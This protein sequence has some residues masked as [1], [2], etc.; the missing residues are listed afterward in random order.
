MLQDARITRRGLLAALGVAPFVRSQEKPGEPAATFSTNVKVVNLYANVRD[1]KGEIV[2][3]LT[4]DDFLL[5]EDGRPQTI[6][7]FSQESNL[8][9]TLGLLVDTSGSQRRLI[10][11]ERDASSRFFDQVLRPDKDVAFLIH[12]DF[13]VELLQDITSSRNL[14]Q[15]ALSDLDAPSQL[16]RRSQG[17]GGG[18][19]GGGYPGGGGGYPGGGGGGYPGGRG[20]RRGGGT[21]LYDAVM[22]GSDE[23]MKK[24]TGRKALI[25]LSDGVDTGSRTTLSNC[26]ESAQRADTLVYSILFE[27]P[28]AYG[29]GGYPMGGMG[30]HG[31]MGG[32]MP[33][34][35]SGRPDG[36]KVLEQISRETG[37]RFFKVTKKE[38][39]ST[40]YAEINDDLRHQYSIGYSP[41]APP[42]NRAF[43]HIHL[44]TKQKGLT[45]TTREGYYPS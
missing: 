1:K 15:K 26:I 35:G 10:G 43:R 7:Y 19:P 40:I 23:I 27:D 32:P 41:D 29:R 42:D 9:L 25:I 12:F 21:D 31:R 24:Q 16:Q 5:D 39:L 37:G 2:K 14:L 45:V 3:D 11:E 38:P 8:P 17:G 22:L 4:K 18:Y 13:E 44:T 6:R 34:P 20:G 36:K 33:A 28:E 30:R